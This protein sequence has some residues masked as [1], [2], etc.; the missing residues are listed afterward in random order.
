MGIDN[1]KKDIIIGEVKILFAKSVRERGNRAG[2]E[3]GRGIKNP[4]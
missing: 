4:G 3:S 2:N 1:K